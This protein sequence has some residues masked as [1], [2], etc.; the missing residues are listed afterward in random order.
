MEKFTVEKFYR[1]YDDETGAYI[2]VR[3]DPDAL[4]M[5]TVQ[6]VNSDDKVVVAVN[7]LRGQ[8]AL[9]ARAIIE[10]EEEILKG[11]QK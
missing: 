1:V 9:V 3:P 4:G 5:V 2:Q 7:I 11:E 10:C 6:E 8:A